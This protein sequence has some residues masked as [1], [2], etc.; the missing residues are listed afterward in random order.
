MDWIARSRTSCRQCRWRAANIVQPLIAVASNPF[1]IPC[2]DFTSLR[3][4]VNNMPVQPEYKDREEA[5][6]ELQRTL[7]RRYREMPFDYDQFIDNY[8]LIVHD[9][10]VNKNSFQ[11][12]LPNSTTGV[13]S[14]EVVFNGALPAVPWMA[15]WIGE[16]RNELKVGY[17]TKPRNIYDY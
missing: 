9:L 1:R 7:D 17:Q 14:Y 13:V 15:I 10:T 2:I 6:W 3:C 4:S 11:Q 5:F 12:T 16:F 8:G